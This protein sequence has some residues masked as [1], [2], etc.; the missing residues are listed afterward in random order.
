MDD[1]G[2]EYLLQPQ[3]DEVL[4]CK[5]ERNMLYAEGQ[6]NRVPNTS[7]SL[8]NSSSTPQRT[9]SKPRLPIVV[10]VLSDNFTKWTE[11]YALPDQEAETIAR[12][13][14]EQ[15]V[16]RFGVPHQLHSDR[17][18]NIESVVFQSVCKLLNI[19][20]TSITSRRS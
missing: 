19:D 10:R 20:K 15:F 9:C 2:T 18:T 11:A 1:E 6:G 5:H 14:V 8:P 7:I 16:C 13:I 4:H 12:A 3:T 17:G